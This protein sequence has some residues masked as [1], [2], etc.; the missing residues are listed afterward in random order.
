MVA[1]C[2]AVDPRFEKKPKIP[3][4]LLEKRDT[5]PLMTPTPTRDGFLVIY[6]SSREGCSMK[7][8]RPVLNEVK[9][10]VGF[11]TKSS[12]PTIL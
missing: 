3:L 4:V 12:D 2:P 6:F 11:P 10:I 8:R 7:S 5:V 1:V 9:S